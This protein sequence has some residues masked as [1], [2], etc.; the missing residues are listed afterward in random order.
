[1]E[2]FGIHVACAGADRDY[3]PNP[4]LVASHVVLFVSDDTSKNCFVFSLAAVLMNSVRRV[5]IPAGIPAVSPDALSLFK[6]AWSVDNRARFT[7][8][9]SIYPKQP[10]VVNTLQR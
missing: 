2:L 10:N 5:E 6:H 7:L 9:P 8:R 4:K 1:M 3:T